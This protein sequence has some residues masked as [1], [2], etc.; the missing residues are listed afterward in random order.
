MVLCIVALIV[1]GILGIFSA[2][3]RKLAVQALDCTVKTVTLRPCDTGLDEKIKTKLI[4]FLLKVSPPVAKFSNKNYD[5]LSKITGILF[6]V[7]FFSSLFFSGQAVYNY[8]AFGNCN[9]PN[10]TEFC[11]FDALLGKNTTNTPFVTPTMLASDLK[12]GNPLANVTVIEFGCYTCPFTKANEG[13]RKQLVEKYK[14]DVRFVF[15]PFP[16]PNHNNSRELAA[17]AIINGTWDFHDK[18]FELQKDFKSMTREQT[19]AKLKELGIAKFEI[20]NSEIQKIV[21]A[22][23]NQGVN[24]KIVGTPTYFIGNAS[25][26]N[27]SFNQMDAV[28]HIALT[29][30]TINHTTAANLGGSCPA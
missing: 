16:L 30:Q 19:L 17:A 22:N 20:D 14:G 28:I 4:G 13:V 25:F 9:G 1:F 18:L 27:P 21:E 8:V 7:L 24:A 3:Y 6:F 23:Y 5:V 26:V 15:K 11:A 2:K 29:G 10:S 12:I